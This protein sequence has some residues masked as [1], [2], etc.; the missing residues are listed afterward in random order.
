MQFVCL[1]VVRTRAAEPEPGILL[2]DGA[3]I[4]N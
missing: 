3:Q 4:K 2:G 1:N